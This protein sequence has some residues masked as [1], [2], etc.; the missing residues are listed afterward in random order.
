MT[1]E[2]RSLRQLATE[3]NRAY[4]QI[5]DGE[6]KSIEYATEIGEMLI[7]AKKKHGEHGK[8]LDWLKVECPDIAETTAALYMRIANKGDELAAAAEANGQ[9]VAD[10]TIRG[11]AR[12]LAKPKKE[13]APRS[14]QPR[15]KAAVEPPEP[16]LGSPD[17]PT[18][19]KNVGPDEVATALK[20]ADW[21]R[22]DVEKLVLILKAAL[23]AP[24]S[25]AEMPASSI[26]RRPLPVSGQ[27]LTQN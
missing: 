26:K 27:G 2:P 23:D 22:D 25:S 11:A 20:Q 3:I 13:G 5:I 1:E 4:Q 19:L 10:L 18:V 14:S 24:A 12:L 16:S 17:L 6:K 8:W 9:R 15:T 7:A 21:T